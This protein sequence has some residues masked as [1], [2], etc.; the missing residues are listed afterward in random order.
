MRN[1]GVSC[2][3]IGIVTVAFVLKYCG[4]APHIGDCGYISASINIEVKNFEARYIWTWTR[5]WNGET[6]PFFHKISSFLFAKILKILVGSLFILFSWQKKRGFVGPLRMAT[7]PTGHKD[8]LDSAWGDISTFL[9]F[10]AIYIFFTEYQFIS[11]PSSKMSS[12][13]RSSLKTTYI[14]SHEN[15][16][17]MQYSSIR[18]NCRDT[19]GANHT[20][21]IKHFERTG[22]GK[23]QDI[24]PHRAVE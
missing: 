11:L 17:K 13:I 6:K 2:R 3:I 1:I 14:L 18:S 10:L 4:T 21:N 7:P 15:S 5:N 16:G 12:N 22:R 20:S 24:P 23:E 9:V 8:R 19:N